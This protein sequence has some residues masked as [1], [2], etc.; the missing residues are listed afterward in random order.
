MQIWLMEGDK[1][2]TPGSA[3]RRVEQAYPGQSEKLFNT[4]VRIIK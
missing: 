3:R 2:Q 1:D 4:R